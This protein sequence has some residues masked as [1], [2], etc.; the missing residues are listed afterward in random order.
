M[1]L[2]T[3][4]GLL[5]KNM[6]PQLRDLQVILSQVILLLMVLELLLLEN[7]IPATMLMNPTQHHKKMPLQLLTLIT[8]HQLLVTTQR[9]VQ[10]QQEV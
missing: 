9:L 5:M 2:Q 3:S 8:Q 10:R 4:T 1:E 6:E 7:K